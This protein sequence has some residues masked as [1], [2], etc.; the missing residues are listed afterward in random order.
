MTGIAASVAGL[1]TIAAGVGLAI[2]TEGAD[3]LVL[4]GLVGGSSLLWFGAGAAFLTI[5]EH[6][7]S[8]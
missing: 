5:E 1:A 2:G 4:A 3:T 7:S 8:G 6:P